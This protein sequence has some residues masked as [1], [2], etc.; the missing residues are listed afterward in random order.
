MGRGLGEKARTLL[1]ESAPLFPERGI[2]CSRYDFAKPH[3]PIRQADGSVLSVQRT[4]KLVRRDG[5]YRTKKAAR[6]LADE[7]LRPFNDG[8][9]T[10]DGTTSVVQFVEESYLPSVETRK[11]PS[12][13]RD[14]KICGVVILSPALMP[15][16]E[17]SEP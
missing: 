10:I 9:V 8:T 16:C 12:T 15:H 3:E 4:H 14:I 6:V 11:R 5:P 17:I 13:Y 7:F 2:G 1:F